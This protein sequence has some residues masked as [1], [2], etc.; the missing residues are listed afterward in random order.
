MSATK[1]AHGVCVHGGPTLGGALGGGDSLSHGLA[2]LAAQKAADTA[3]AKPTQAEPS[4]P[5]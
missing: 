5:K 2:C 3:C 1:T 4:K